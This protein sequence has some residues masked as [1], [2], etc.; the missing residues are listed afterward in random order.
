MKFRTDFVTNS[1]SSSYFV[2]VAITDQAGESYAFQVYPADEYIGGGGDATLRVSDKKVFAAKDLEA[3]CD[4]LVDSID[5][6]DADVCLDGLR[7]T[8][9]KGL[10]EYLS[11]EGAEE[12]HP[13]YFDWVVKDAENFKAELKTK[14][15]NLENVATVQIRQGHT[16]GGEMNDLEDYIYDL[17][18]PDCFDGDEAEITAYL[19]KH[20]NENSDIKTLAEYFSQ[21]D[22]PD[23]FCRLCAKRL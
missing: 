2:E 18:I 1:S 19:T 8:S 10:R 23:F 22:Y 20:L 14:V 9:L 3:L 6:A 15:K 7:D 11:N 4:L 12:E 5:L 13:Q 21:G 17:G 16:A